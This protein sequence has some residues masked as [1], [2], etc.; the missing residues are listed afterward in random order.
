M[1]VQNIVTLIVFVIIFGLSTYNNY[2]KQEE[3]KRKAREKR[4]EEPRTEPERPFGDLLGELLGLPE[5]PAKPSRPESYA[6]ME[7]EQPE[8]LSYQERMKAERAENER[9][10]EAE[11][12]RKAKAMIAFKRQQQKEDELSDDEPVSPRFDLRDAIIKQIILERRDY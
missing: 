3:E 8:R 1:D 4:G 5:V 10:A 11:E 9:V 6:P 12:V 7:S 2:R